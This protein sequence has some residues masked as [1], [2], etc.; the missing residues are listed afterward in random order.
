MSFAPGTP[1]KTKGQ[2]E[3][4]KVVNLKI[5]ETIARSRFP[6]LFFLCFYEPPNSEVVST[7]NIIGS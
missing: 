1:T 2:A 3:A 7:E 4:Q 6:D 5:N